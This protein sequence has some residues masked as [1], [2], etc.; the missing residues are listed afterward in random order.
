MVGCR[1]VGI[2]TPSNLCQ[3]SVVLSFTILD[4]MSLAV[5][6]PVQKRGGDLHHTICNSIFTM[7]SVLPMDTSEPSEVGSK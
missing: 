7:S 6:D 4:I 2:M 3:G 1:D 5:S